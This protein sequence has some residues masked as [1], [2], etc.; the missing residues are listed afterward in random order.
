MKYLLLF[1]LLAFVWWLFSKRQNRGADASP[2]Q[3]VP[4]KMVTCVHCGVHL[5][6]S[7][8]LVDGAQIYCCEAHRLA[9]RDEVR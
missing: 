4:E 2:K 7:E 8:G 6:E 9:A 3:A 1:V 5:P